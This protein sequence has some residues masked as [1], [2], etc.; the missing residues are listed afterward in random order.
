[1]TTAMPAYSGIRPV[2]TAGA[3]PPRTSKAFGIVWD[4]MMADSSIKSCW[5]SLV[6]VRPGLKD[7]VRRLTKMDSAARTR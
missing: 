1:M 6:R 7:T 2:R 5:D 3:S 4:K